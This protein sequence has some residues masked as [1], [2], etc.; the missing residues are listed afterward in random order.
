MFWEPTDR[1]LFMQIQS[2]RNHERKIVLVQ[3]TTCVG[4][5]FEKSANGEKKFISLPKS[6][7]NIG[8]DEH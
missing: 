7:T 1:V 5:S 6:P 3:T 8:S 2:D 4:F